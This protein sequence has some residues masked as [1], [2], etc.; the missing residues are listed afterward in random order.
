MLIHLRVD[1]KIVVVLGGTYHWAGKGLGPDLNFFV[2][3]KKRFNSSKASKT[4]KN[5]IKLS[6]FMCSTLSFIWYC[7]LSVDFII[8]NFGE[9]IEEIFVFESAKLFDQGILSKKDSP[10]KSDSF[11]IAV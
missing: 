9:T 2:K 5:T 11:T 4:Y 6:K 8:N 7:L 10:N 3:K 1:V